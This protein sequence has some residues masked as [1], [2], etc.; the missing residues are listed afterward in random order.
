MRNSEGEESKKRKKL[1]P[2]KDNISWKLKGKR[3][4]NMLKIQELKVLFQAHLNSSNNKP[5]T[6]MII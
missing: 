6:T 5:L 4:N 2:E 1:K 3:S